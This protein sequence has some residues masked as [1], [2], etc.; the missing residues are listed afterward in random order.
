LLF[1]F[2]AGRAVPVLLGGWAMGALESLRVL[3]RYQRWFEVGGAV[4]LIAAGLYML[5]AYFIV[6]P[7]L[8]V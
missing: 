5:N 4:L 2:A 6:I 1:A 7:E 8:A 3:A